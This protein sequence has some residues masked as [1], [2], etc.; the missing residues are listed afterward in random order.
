M[1]ADELCHLA[2]E[3]LYQVKR[4]SRNNFVY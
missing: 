3:K 2:D 1:S 4:T